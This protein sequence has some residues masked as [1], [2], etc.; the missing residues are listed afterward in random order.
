MQPTF[1]I[2]HSEPMTDQPA[3]SHRG[4]PTIVANPAGDRAFRAR[5]EECLLAGPSDPSELEQA[6]QPAYPTVVVR[7]RELSNEPIEVWYAYRDGHWV[8]RNPDARG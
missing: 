6:L 5:I 8:G 7:R 3:K 2:T 4:R 1:R